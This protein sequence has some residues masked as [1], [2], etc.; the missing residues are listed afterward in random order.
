MSILLP[1]SLVLSVFL[2][3]S[4]EHLLL[5]FLSSQQ[6]EPLLALRVTLALGSLNL[7]C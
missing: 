2:I 4:K 5:L 1:L 6:E 7:A 3:S